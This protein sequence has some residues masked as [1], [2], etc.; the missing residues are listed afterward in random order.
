LVNGAACGGKPPTPE[1]AQRLR[2]PPGSAM[3]VVDVV[4]ER[5]PSPSVH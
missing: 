2:P 4:R 5:N 1:D 3:V